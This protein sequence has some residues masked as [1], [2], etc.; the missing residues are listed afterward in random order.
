MARKR[1][2]AG[3]DIGTSK[4]TT[5]IT[6]VDD[7]E[8]L[9]IIGVAKADSRGIRKGQIVDIESATHAVVS[10]LEAAER[11]AGYELKSAF[12]SVGGTHIASQ[13]SK[14]V[15]AV[16]DP[17]SEI[18][19]NDIA[20]VI[21]AAKAVSLGSA[22]KIIHVLPRYFTVDSQE[23]I[24]DPV[25]MSG[26]RL[27]VDTHLVTGGLT[28]LKNVEKCLA[29]VGIDTEGFVYNGLASA[30]SVLTDTEKELGVVLLDIGAGTTDIEI[31]VEGA[32][33]Y[34]TVLPIG[35]RNVTNDIAIG[36][37]ISLESAEKLKLFLGSEPDKIVHPESSGSD[38]VRRKSAKIKSDEIDLSVL[39]L[40]EGLNK[41]SKKTLIDGIIR[42]RL[43]E[44]FNVAVSEIKKSGFAGLVP[45]GI[46]IT[47]GG[48]LT[49]G[50][51]DA[52]RR[53]IALPFRIG[54]PYD[55]KGVTDE[56]SLPSF[57][58]AIGLAKYGTRMEQRQSGGS[59]LSLPGVP[60]GFNLKGTA[61]K[62][63]DLV[64]SFL[65]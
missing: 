8:N 5:V 24:K 33:S 23:G 60:K 54:A 34:S 45:S 63:I 50:I 44:L 51:Q 28:S 37:R 55:I 41:V 29:N 47:G 32:P 49:A 56:V 12:V 11:M 65:P 17:N 43:N 14:G 58:T 38:D 53:T 27:E 13:N 39:N 20:R 16:A 59:M 62:L 19:E 46:V 7:D 21:D 22:R 57:A 1:I 52:A 18:S 30:E 25:G 3:I 40:T 35:A 61:D 42:P 31:Y 48:A 15:V 64:K 26:V 9:S 4:T 2:I 6:S 36:L 10:S